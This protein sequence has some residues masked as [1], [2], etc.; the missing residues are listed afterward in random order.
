MEIEGATERGKGVGGGGGDA[1]VFPSAS[2]PSSSNADTVPTASLL[3]PSRLRILSNRYT[4]HK[5]HC[6]L[7]H[8]KTKIKIV[9]ADIQL[10]NS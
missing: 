5:S 1:W 8:L 10:K 3:H 9:Q 6:F 2:T 7:M 4:E